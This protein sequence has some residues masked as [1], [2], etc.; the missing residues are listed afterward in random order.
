MKRFALIAATLLMVSPVFAASYSIDPSHTQVQF[1]YNHFGFSNI[2]GRFDQISGKFELD[3]KDLS[4]SEISVEIP[5]NSISTGVEKLDAHLQSPDFFDAAKYPIA[6]FKSKSV[7]VISDKELHV[8]GDLT[9]HGVT[10]PITLLVKVNNI[11]MHPMRKVPSAGFDASTTLK[12]SDFGVGAYVPAVSDEV[13]ITISME[14]SEA[15]Q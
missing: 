5:I 4:K 1:E 12:R 14:A 10:K 6:S 7:Q 8:N 3:T 2:T 11:A 9:I 13:K 15:K